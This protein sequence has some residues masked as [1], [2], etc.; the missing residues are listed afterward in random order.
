MNHTSDKP[1]LIA[2]I[3]HG[4]APQIQFTLIDFLKALLMFEHTDKFIFCFTQCRGIYPVKHPDFKHQI[5]S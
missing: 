3:L 4:Q 5:T 2:R 1:T